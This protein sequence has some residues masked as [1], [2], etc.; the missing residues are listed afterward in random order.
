MSYIIQIHP[1]YLL[2]FSASGADSDE[3]EC[4]LNGDDVPLVEE[5]MRNMAGAGGDSDGGFGDGDGS[6]SSDGNRDDQNG[7]GNDDDGGANFMEAVLNLNKDLAERN[8]REEEEDSDN[9]S[10]VIVN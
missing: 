6:S 2:C 8:R 9:P 4:G 10:E 1:F 5:V 3:D 7:W